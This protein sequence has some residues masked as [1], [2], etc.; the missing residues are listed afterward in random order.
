MWVSKY[1]IVLKGQITFN[2]GLNTA[3]NMH[4][5]QKKHQIKVVRN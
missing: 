4:H 3:K 5:I 1:Y 2:L